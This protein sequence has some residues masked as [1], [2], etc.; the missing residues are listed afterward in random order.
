MTTDSTGNFSIELAN[1]DYDVTIKKTGYF[2][3]EKKVT[4]SDADLEA[5]NFTME[6]NPVSMLSGQTVTGTFRTTDADTVTADGEIKLTYAGTDSLQPKDFTLSSEK[7]GTSYDGVTLLEVNTEN[8]TGSI[9]IQF[10]KSL[11]L[12]STNEIQLYVRYKGSSIGSIVLKKEI[13]LVQLATPADVR[14]DETVKGKAVWS[15]VTNASGYKV[16]L[17]KNGSVLGDEVTLGADAASYDFTSQIAESGTYTFGVRATGDGSTYD[18]S[19]EAK[20]GNYEFSEQT[21]AAVE[22][23][24]QEALRAMTVTNKTTAEE[25]LQVVQKVIKNRKIQAKWSNENEFNL[26]PATNGEDPGQNGS[27]TGTIVLSYTAESASTETKTIE[28][29]LSIAAKYAIT[30]ASGSSGFAGRGTDTGKCR[31]QNCDY[32]SGEYL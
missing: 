29:N 25:I 28:I 14:W 21:L 5:L 27:I 1:G 16:Q 15:L 19:E 26:A 11:A 17:Y 20:S 22:T 32:A 8:G 13:K 12:G 4:I 6:T 2:T 31:S 9:K 24:A 30:F 10:A 7:D 23:A 18:D 3:V